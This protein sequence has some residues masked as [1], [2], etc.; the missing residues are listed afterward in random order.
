[1]IT[2]PAAQ[3][4]CRRCGAWLPV[5]PDSAEFASYVRERPDPNCPHRSP[6][7]SE[8]WSPF[9]VD[10]FYC[11]DCVVEEPVEE[12]QYRFSCHACGWPRHRTDKSGPDILLPKDLRDVWPAGQQAHP[13]AWRLPQ[14]L[15]VHVN[16]VAARYCYIVGE[17]E[18][19]ALPSLLDHAGRR[20][21]N[22]G[23]VYE[24]DFGDPHKV[25]QS[26][27]RLRH[28]RRDGEDARA[29]WLLAERAVLAI[30]MLYV[31]AGRLARRV[32]EQ[33]RPGPLEVAPVLGGGGLSIEGRYTAWME[34]HQGFPW[35]FDPAERWHDRLRRRFAGLPDPE[36]PTADVPEHLWPFRHFIEVADDLELF[37]SACRGGARAA[38]EEIG[39]RR[40]VELFKSLCGR[41][42]WERR[43]L[44][45]PR[46]R[47]PG[48]IPDYQQ[49]L[50]AQFI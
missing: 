42:E 25:R 6:T 33:G 26:L 34:V 22:W 5:R 30:N 43:P 41:G 3:E 10:N 28:A 21:A 23:S 19:A 20:V 13:A 45:E 39:M 16:F 35:L 50:E 24:D 29:A 38:S 15:I 1:M 32:D 14:T 31:Q 48:Y 37:V 9:A 47:E 36:I 44:Y 11:D 46:I 7:D 8:I 18:L 49:G 17:E 40:R 27:A 4:I 12:W 2:D